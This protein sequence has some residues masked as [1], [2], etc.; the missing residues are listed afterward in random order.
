[1]TVTSVRGRPQ[2][3]P[4]VR[5]PS[6]RP[7]PR[8]PWLEAFVAGMSSAR[9]SD[10]AAAH[11]RLSYLYG[12]A[13]SGK[14]SPSGPNPALRR[15]IVAGLDRE[16]GRGGRLHRI[17]EAHFTYAQILIHEGR[18]EDAR[19]ELA[20]AARLSGGSLLWLAADPGSGNHPPRAGAGP[21]G[22]P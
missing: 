4:Q 18:F 12:E 13:V 2:G 17:P 22:A 8:P 16:T 15:Q 14:G 6:T 19:R 9:Q 21:G 10:R 1:M 20:E 3:P 5:Q 11:F 7:G